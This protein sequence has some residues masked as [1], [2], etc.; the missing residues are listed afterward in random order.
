MNN[1]EVGY[2]LKITMIM[3]YDRTLIT[4]KDNIVKYTKNMFDELL[5]QS[6]NITKAYGI[7]TVE[8]LL[9]KL[10]LQKT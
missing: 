2:K 7:V 8:E 6:D 5:N 4:D 10:T 3:L 1:I 9:D